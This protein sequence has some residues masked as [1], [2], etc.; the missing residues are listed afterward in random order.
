MDKI[1]DHL[2]VFNGDGK[3]D[4]FPGNYSDYRAYN[5]SSLPWKKEHNSAKKPKTEWK[6]PTSLKTTLN[7]QEQKEFKKLE[8]EIELL[9]VSKK[10]LQNH[11]V[12][13]SLSPEKII[14]I[15]KELAQLSIDLEEKSLRWLTLSISQE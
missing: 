12:K 8:R 15:S 9:E 4:D 2:F 11:F 1:V 5:Q 14:E 3:I 6:K 7:Y 13:S 10:T